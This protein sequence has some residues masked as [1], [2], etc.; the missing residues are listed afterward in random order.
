[1][2][3]QVAFMTIGTII[4][5]WEEVGTGTS[6]KE[7]KVT[8][9]V[10]VVVGQNQLQLHPLLGLTTSKSCTIKESDLIFGGL[11]EPQPD[12]RNHYSAQYGSGI[13]LS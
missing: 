7:W 9:P 10:V 4:G 2:N 5:D 12:L 8:N 6:Q 1:M 13:Q 3:I 11:H